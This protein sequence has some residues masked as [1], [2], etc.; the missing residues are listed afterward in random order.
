MSKLPP[1]EEIDERWSDLPLPDA[2]AA[3]RDMSARLDR[4]DG[5]RRKPPFLPTILSGCTGWAFLL[6]VLAGSAIGVYRHYQGSE[7]RS[8]ASRP[9]G[10]PGLAASPTEGT[11][12]TTQPSS[13]PAVASTHGNTTPTAQPN[14]QP[15]N[16]SR[17]SLNEG[18]PDLRGF[19]T[20]KADPHRVTTNQPDRGN[21]GEDKTGQKPA[22]GSTVLTKRSEGDAEHETA[23]G[24]RNGNS[25][26]KGQDVHHTSGGAG[27]PAVTGVPN[28]NLSG[29]GAASSNAG[30]SGRHSDKTH[31]RNAIA[32]AE[33]AP[34]PASGQPGQEPAEAAAPS[35]TRRP[36]ASGAVTLTSPGQ[37]SGKKARKAATGAETGRKPK[38][39]GTET[40]G[41]TPATAAGTPLTGAP[42]TLPPA[43]DGADAK[44]KQAANAPAN[45]VGT[46]KTTA[47]GSADTTVA[48]TAW[49]PKNYPDVTVVPD[50]ALKRPV[51]SA[52][53]AA[54]PAVPKKPAR[55]A[56]WL[57]AGAGISQPFALGNQQSYSRNY[58]G[59]F[60]P[61]TEHVPSLWLR[62]HQGRW[63]LQAETRFNAPQPVPDVTFSQKTRWDTGAHAVQTERLQL[64]KVWYHEFPLTLNYQVLPRW[65]IGAGAQWSVLYRAAGER[66]TK[67]QD[68]GSSFVSETRSPYQVG[69]FRDSFL[70][71]TQ[72]QLVFQTEVAW[73]RWGLGLRYR[74]DLEPF[75]RY[76]HP[77]GTVSD[78]RNQSF[79]A[80]L[81]FR[82][83]QSQ[84]R[85]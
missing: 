57:S 74:T 81:R 14:N 12:E 26:V 40:P 34:A 85:R 84:K 79:E 23:I 65:S 5:E 3:W 50:S 67:R 18:E 19:S 37:G 33:G 27:R 2:D 64:R 39:G 55:R 61:F 68:L 1:F 63:F 41:T 21:T 20:G 53:W 72:W 70:F 42:G 58:Q 83:W 38:P 69:G 47:A 54:A 9:N 80:T 62:V 17:R 11:R 51:D 52:A 31:R 30:T 13:S 15:A 45:A 76:T 35:G 22:A 77:D 49:P 73:H 82:I 28:A 56:P 29:T 44:P 16:S 60:N 75:L 24:V 59:H 71:K 8:A 6:L 78:V 46:A 4:E 10:I 25:T 7:N 48:I 43:A 66:V 32:Q 36:K